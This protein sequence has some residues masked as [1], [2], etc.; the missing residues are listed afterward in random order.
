MHQSFTLTAEQT[1]DRNAGPFGDDVGYVVLRH[2]IVDDLACVGFDELSFSLLEFLLEICDGLV[3][4]PGGG[5]QFTFALGIL[6]LHLC[7]IDSLFQ[8]LYLIDVTD[9]Y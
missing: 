4:E 9:E 5:F 1:C 6:K 7:S 2:L 3:F 8:V